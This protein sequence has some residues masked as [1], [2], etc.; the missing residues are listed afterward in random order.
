M[1]IA[2]FDIWRAVNMLVKRHG[3]DA[4]I[5]AAQRA[6]EYLA[7]GDADGQVVWKRIVGAILELVKDKSDEGEHVN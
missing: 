2:D 6:D 3:R 7:V 1:T 4:A 5:I